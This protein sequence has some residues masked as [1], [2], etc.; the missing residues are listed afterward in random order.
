[1]RPSTAAFFCLGLITTLAGSASADVIQLAR[2]RRLEGLI[3]RETASQI[4]LQI[5]WK[6][7][8][9]LDRSSIVAITLS[10]AKDRE[11]LLAQWRQEFAE[12]QTH[13]RDRLAFEEQQRRR[14]MVKVKG[15]WISQDELALMEREREAQAA[16]RREEDTKR[17]EEL[18]R[19]Q[20]QDEQQRILARLEAIEQ[21]NQRLRAELDS[22]PRMVYVPAP[23][24]NPYVVHHSG[25]DLYRDEQGNLIR[26]ERRGGQK[27]FTRSDGVRVDVQQHDS[28][29]AFT[30]PQGIHHDLRQ[31]QELDNGPSRIIIRSRW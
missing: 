21:E 25:A 9:T 23:Y 29:L 10:D 13:E 22:R 18:A 11:H 24:P 27:F 16:K 7:F 17:Q 12:D 19:R 30:D 20:Q 31:V 1:M 3:V 14:G 26:I 15:E 6:G 28:H 2:G 5:A 4:E 8:M